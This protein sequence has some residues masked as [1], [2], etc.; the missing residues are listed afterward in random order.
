MPDFLVAISSVPTFSTGWFV[1]RILQKL[2]GRG[3]S[4]SLLAIGGFDPFSGG[5]GF[6]VV[7]TADSK[8]IV[9][10]DC[11]RVTQ[12]SFCPYSPKCVE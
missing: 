9:G 12:F 5:P 4:D 3:G 2:S 10:G 1:F 8:D 11:E 6:D 7:A